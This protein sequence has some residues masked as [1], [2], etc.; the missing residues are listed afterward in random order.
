MEVYATKYE[1]F[2][3]IFVTIIV[4]T[5]LVITIIEMPEKKLTDY[6][7]PMLILILLIIINI[8]TYLSY[9]GKIPLYRVKE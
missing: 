8:F 7:I 5:I 9:K 6:L 2:L 4:S 1:L 3:S